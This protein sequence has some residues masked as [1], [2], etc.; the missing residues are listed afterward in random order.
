MK[1]NSILHL[2]TLSCTLSQ[3][4][5]ATTSA[6][7][8][9]DTTPLDKT[10]PPGC[11]SR[12]KD[13]IFLRNGSDKLTCIPVGVGYYSPEDSSERFAC[14]P[15]KV[16]T[17]LL[18]SECLPC[19]SGTMALRDGSDCIPCPFGSYQDLP[20]QAVCKSC[21]PARFKGQGSDAITSDGY[22]LSR[23][24]EYSTAGNMN[25]DMTSDSKC[26]NTKGTCTAGCWNENDI[27]LDNGKRLCVPVEPGYY[28]P[29]HSNHRLECEKGSVSSEYKSEECTP[30]SPGSISHPTRTGCVQCPPGTFQDAFGGQVC[31]SCNPDV[32]S[33]PG[34]NRISSDGFCM[35]HKKEIVLKKLDSSV[36]RQDVRR[37]R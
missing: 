3:M 5:V 27:R 31:Y 20:G 28:S 13:N 6:S 36:V 4:L 26:I 9:C 10:C 21:N 19:P 34:A 18:A 2:Y 17:S 1:R 22:C 16:S 15:G 24:Q 8:I 37:R 14:S 25:D 35:L 32:F 7:S 11:W 33:R 30:C 29:A 12:G 23:T